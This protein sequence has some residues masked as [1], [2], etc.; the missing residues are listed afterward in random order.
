MNEVIPEY[1]VTINGIYYMSRNIK[2]REFVNGF[3]GEWLSALSIKN[4]E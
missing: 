4:T 2:F 3:V 1:T